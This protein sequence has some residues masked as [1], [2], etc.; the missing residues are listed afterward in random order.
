[1]KTYLKDFEIEKLINLLAIE[2]HFKKIIKLKKQSYILTP[3]KRKTTI[4]DFYSSKI[5]NNHFYKNN[6]SRQEF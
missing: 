6:I 1:M 4:F 5:Y 3:H 2:T